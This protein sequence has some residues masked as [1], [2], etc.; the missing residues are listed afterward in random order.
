MLT[1]L[2]Q[3]MP[4]L[5]TKEN[6]NALSNWEGSWGGL[7]SLSWVRVTKTGEARPSAFPPSAQ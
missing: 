5:S 1:V 2:T 6:I 3:D 7:A 4:D